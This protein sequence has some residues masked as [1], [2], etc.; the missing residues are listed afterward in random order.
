VTLDE[1]DESVESYEEGV[2]HSLHEHYLASL[3]QID[4]ARERTER[5]ELG[6]CVDCGDEITFE[7]LVAYPLALRC[8]DCQSQHEKLRRAGATPKL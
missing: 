2:N 6:S 4:E 5:G 3:R 8:V 1:G 7:R